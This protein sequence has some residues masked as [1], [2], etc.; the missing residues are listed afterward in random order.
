MVAAL[1][2]LALL[3]L[4]GCND[5]A[6]AAWGSG[7]SRP[8]GVAGSA[9]LA[10]SPSEFVP[11]APIR[12]VDTRAPGD[13][14]GPLK[15]GMVRQ[16]DLSAVVPA[17][18][19]AVTFNITA[20]GQTA[21]GFLQVAPLGAAALSSST[22]NWGGPQETIANGYVTSVTPERKAQIT[23][24]STGQTHVVLDI[25]GYFAPPGTTGA[26]LFTGANYRIY[27]S[28]QTGGPLQPGQSRTLSIYN[29]V[30]TWA[31]GAT[32]AM[33]TLPP[34]PGPPTAASINVTATGTTGSGVFTAAKNVSSATSTVNWTG[35]A[36]TIAN[37]V[38]TDVAPDGSFTVTNNGRSPADL[39][40]DLT[41]T[42]APTASGAP[43]AQYY[44]MPN[45][46]A[47]DSRTLDGPLSRGTSRTTPLPIP[48]DATGV[49]VNTTVTGTVGSNYLTVH[50]S[51]GEVPFTSTMNWYAS[52]TTRANGVFVSLWDN[53]CRASLGFGPGTSTQY[54]YDIAGYFR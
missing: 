41:G 3:V 7:A 44:P 19:T 22:V 13:P 30:D 4:T 53:Q 17:G 25:T 33:T 9:P 23:V 14:T 39:V 46:R 36:Q 37:A 50:A 20:T 40:V 27:D 11:I 42:F 38:V 43:G 31:L 49:A 34:R 6:A 28:R 29:Y 47:Y 10:I 51:I 52:S 18:T 35:P 54:L 15:Q 21:S 32:S 16:V 26:A 8:L 24:V 5:V 1:V 45:T 12:V 48:A 2:A